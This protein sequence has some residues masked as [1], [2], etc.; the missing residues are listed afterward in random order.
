MN[1]KCVAL[2]LLGDYRAPVLVLVSSVR[3]SLHAPHEAPDSGGR[4]LVRPDVTANQ[5]A[6]AP[7]RH[8]H[9]PSPISSAFVIRAVTVVSQ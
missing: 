3:E 9:P 2:N 8:C 1:N 6:L 4:R 7:P 5:R